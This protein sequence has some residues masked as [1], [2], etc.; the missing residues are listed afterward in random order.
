[1]TEPVLIVC[2]R[3]EDPV[4]NWTLNVYD[5]DDVDATGFML[6]WTLTLFGEQDPAFKGTPIHL[7]TS[8]HEDK[9]D[10]VSTTIS[11]TT[12]T[13][14]IA[15][16]TT[17]DTPPRPT[18]NKIS[19]T[20]K[21]TTTTTTSN[22]SEATTST[23]LNDSNEQDLNSISDNEPEALANEDDH[24]Y[25]TIV[26]GVFGS[27]AI[28]GVA[29]ALYFYK[30]S[31]WQS[32]VT[33]VTTNDRHLGPGGYEFDVLQPLTELDEDELSESDSDR[34]ENA[35]LVRNDNQS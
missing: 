7:S 19:S 22:T 31:G 8:I 26:Y 27:I 13:A 17:D 16:T 21:V 34:E 15:T 10:Q 1:L 4:G 14:T 6:N 9:E 25:L 5:V 20:K 28:L 11:T 35:R 24:S 12:T 32:P 18:R 30:R 29:S 33:T 2:H 3:E 23:H